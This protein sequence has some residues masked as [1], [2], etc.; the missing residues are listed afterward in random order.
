MRRTKWGLVLSVI[1]ILSA[2]VTNPILEPGADGEFKTGL[3]LYEQG[4]YGD[5]IEHFNRAIDIDPEH[6]R[7]YLYLGR[8]LFHLG[9]WL[10]AVSYLRGA[11]LRVPADQQKEVVAELL[12]SM[13]KGAFELFQKGNFVN[14]IAM[15]KEALRLSPDSSRAKE[16][17]GEVMSAFGHELFSE[18]RFTEAVSAYSESLSLTPDK[19][20]S[21]IGMARAYFENGDF[22]EAPKTLRQAMKNVPESDE[23]KDLFNQLLQGG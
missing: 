10:E 2:C 17:L 9:R 18:G 1:L 3:A 15:L 19:V 13:L 6:A 5:A 7:S 14:A 23:V 20:Q 8:S 12:D 11:Y 22:S 16:D 21:Y 4:R